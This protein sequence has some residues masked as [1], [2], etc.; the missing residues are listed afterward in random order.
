[1][2][3][4]S[5][6]DSDHKQYII[7]LEDIMQVQAEV[8]LQRSFFDPPNLEGKPQCYIDFGGGEQLL[9]PD[10]DG[11]VYRGVSQALQMVGTFITNPEA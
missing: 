5:F 2:K 3:F 11:S 10:V 1:M 6:K 4:Y 8:R 9:V 7:N